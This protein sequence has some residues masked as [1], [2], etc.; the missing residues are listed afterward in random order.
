MAQYFS[1][2]RFGFAPHGE[3]I[4]RPPSQSSWITKA[5]LALS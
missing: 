4:I 3:A 1:A 2:L 5:K